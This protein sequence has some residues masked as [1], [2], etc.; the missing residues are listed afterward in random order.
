MFQKALKLKQQDKNEPMKPQ[1]LDLKTSNFLLM[2]RI[3]TLLT[4]QHLE[5]EAFQDIFKW[6]RALLPFGLANT[7]APIAIH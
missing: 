6:T 2:T 5:L 4:S 3:M 1:H 7:G